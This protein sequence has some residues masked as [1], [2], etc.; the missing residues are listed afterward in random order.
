[1]DEGLTTV[2]IQ[3][4]LSE[5]QVQALLS[6]ITSVFVSFTFAFAPDA[7]RAVKTASTPRLL[8]STWLLFPSQFIGDSFMSLCQLFHICFSTQIIL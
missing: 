7:I 5:A 2:C 8:V 4:Y 3:F 1:M 6:R